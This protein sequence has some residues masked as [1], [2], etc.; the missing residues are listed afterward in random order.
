VVKP[1]SEVE[2]VVRL[3]TTRLPKADQIGTN[4]SGSREPRTAARESISVRK[5]ADG[6]AAR[7]SID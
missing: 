5:G 6:A 2:A 7:L 1:R 4:E 3:P